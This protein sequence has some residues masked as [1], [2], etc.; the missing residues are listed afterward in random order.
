M[1]GSG[2]VLKMG[3][4]DIGRLYGD[5]AIPGLLGFLPS[6]LSLWF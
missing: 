1:P 3:V 2:G 5:D 6:S 4:Q